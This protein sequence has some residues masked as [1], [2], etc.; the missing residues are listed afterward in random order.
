MKAF[1]LLKRLQLRLSNDGFKK[2]VKELFYFNRELILVRKDLVSWKAK[3][4]DNDLEY[5]VVDKTNSV[6]TEK[7]LNLHL[8]DHY[9]KIHCKT[10]VAIKDEVCVGFIRWTQDKN[11][12]DL[13][14]YNIPL[15]PDEAYMFDFFLFPTYRG[16]PVIRDIYHYAMHH[17]KSIGISRYYGFF[18]ADNVP[19]LWWHRTICRTEEFEKVKAHKLVFLE[20][21]NNKLFM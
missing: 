3:P 9:G 13:R 5:I 16:T 11:F 18:Y 8:F 2:T 7:R 19:A 4:F 1:Y 12:K 15:A 17:L 10:L 20:M 14:K 6:E 21:I